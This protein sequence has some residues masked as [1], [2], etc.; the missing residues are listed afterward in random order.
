MGSDFFYFM[1]KPYLNRVVVDGMEWD[2]K[3]HLNRKL[4]N[5]TVNKIVFGAFDYDH[6]L[7]GD[8][9]NFTG[10]LTELNI[11]S[12]A[13]SK[14][15]MMDMTR[16]CSDVIITPDI[17]NWSEYSN[18]L[19]GDTEIKD[20]NHLCYNGSENIENQLIFQFQQDYNGAFHTCKTLQGKLYHPKSLDGH[21]DLTGIIIKFSTGSL[22]WVL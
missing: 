17:L 1:K 5:V 13:L 8:F 22:R 7:S 18:L 14:E 11:W 16:N 2:H 12:K 6:P 20:I 21:K 19:E 10:E 9:D 3:D 15:S 4:K